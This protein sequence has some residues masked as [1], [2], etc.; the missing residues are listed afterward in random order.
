MYHWLS[1]FISK[2]LSVNFQEEIWKDF[3]VIQLYPIKLVLFQQLRNSAK[4][5]G[6]YL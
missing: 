1:N 3:H 2:I 6:T 5:D 4:S